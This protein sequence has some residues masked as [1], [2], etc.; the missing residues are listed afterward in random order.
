MTIHLLALPNAQT[1]TKY[2][3]CGFTMATI[4]MAKLL[5]K[6][7]HR[8][9]L[10]ASEENEA[11]C[12]ELV[13]VITKEEQ[14]TILDG[15]EYQYAGMFNQAYPLWALANNRTTAAIHKRKEP[16]DIIFTI[17][18]TS[19]E[20]IATA[21]PDLM[22]VEYSVGYVS[23][24]AAY[25]VFE[26]H[27]WRAWTYGRNRMET[28]RFFD[29]VIP[30]W[31]D[32]KDF[33]GIAGE[34]PPV[35]HDYALFVGRVIESKGIRVACEAAEKAGLQLYVIG[36]GDP[37]TV[38]HGAKYLG[39]LSNAE[40]NH[41]M[42]WARC[43]VAPTLYIEPFGTV[44]IEA[45]MSGTPVVSTDWG[46]FIETV[47]HGVT[48]FRCRT[49]GDFVRGISESQGLDRQAVYSRCREKY[50]ENTVALQYERYINRLR[51]LHRDGWNSLSE[52]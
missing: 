17:G 15:M 29:E 31:L 50:S 2:E 12:D 52:Y 7:R 14:K 39:A 44:A 40:R 47:E 23:S 26:S 16:G 10:Y 41:Y 13:T 30:L 19:Q 28:G 27:Y 37:S 5:R 32:P 33:N 48:G 11:P 3:L 20:P 9:I 35:R 42:R 38:T 43:L 8:V 22:T 25:R 46:G 1:T 18:G 4:R 6:L 21:N 24:F 45:Q 36:H 51:L 34:E 49:L